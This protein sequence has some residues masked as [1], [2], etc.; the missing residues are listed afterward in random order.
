MRITSYRSVLVL[1]IVAG[2]ALAV[3]PAAAP[4]EPA[5]PDLIPEARRLL[6]YLMSQQNRKIVSGV[7]RKGPWACVLQ[8]SGR[9]PAIWGTDANGWSTKY[10]DRYHANLRGMIDECL[11]WWK[12]K[13]GIVQIHFHWAMPTVEKGSA[14]TR[15]NPQQ[16]DLEKTFTPGTREY[17][18]FHEDLSVTA[19][20]LEQ[21][22]EAKV[23]VVWR[24]FHEIDGGWF[25]WTDSE[26]PENTAALYRQMFQYLVKE[27]GLHNLIW[28]Y[29][30]AH[31]SGHIEAVARSDPS[32]A[33]EDEI[34]YRKRFYPGDAY[35]D[36]AS[37]DTYGNPRLGWN[38][39]WGDARQ[40]A[41]ELMVGVAPGKPLAIGEDS[42]LLNP[43]IAEREGPP[44]LYDMAWWAN[45]P[46]WVHYTYNHEHV[47]TLDELP[48][49]HDGNV[50][51]NVRI[52]WPKDSA[53]LGTREIDLAGFASDRNGNLEDV[54]LYALS[55]P[56]LNFHAR[57]SN[58][59]RITNPSV[60][61]IFAEG[62]CLGSARIGDLGRWTFTWRNVP[63]GYQQ[64]AA[65]ARD[66][67]GAVMASN[68]VRLRVR[69]DNLAFGKTVTAS[70]TAPNGKHPASNAVD[71]NPYTM[72]RSDRKATGPQW[73]MVDLGSVRTVG[74]A[75]VLWYGAYAKDYT[76]QVSTDG[77]EWREVARVEN[78]RKP[79]GDADLL[80]F[81]PVKARYVRLYCIEPAVDWEHYCI[82]DF[83]VYEGIPE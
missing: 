14:W 57:A 60:E 46:D 48:V 6:D 18:A 36:I 52:E 32:F 54:T 51:P 35:V 67:E 22:A 63:S 8:F 68:V 53:G 28:V 44:W 56:W 34:A 80:R 15:R 61:E 33:L 16:L 55:G 37:I 4:S 31:R 25:W 5:D 24:P 81:D 47:V 12:E 76:V 72:W 19:D 10:D 7:S 9:D 75:H 21:L 40:K 41:Y 26:K 73:L 69:I 50:M 2:V 30:A 70:T 45:D 39:P 65:I 64:V 74:G 62:T 1:C 77:Q 11:Y 27:R 43:D 59:C 13:G 29:N 20:Y 78:R 82:F 58:G 71:G 79:A 42:G 49:L 66:T 83:A 3:G 38:T 17:E 23:P